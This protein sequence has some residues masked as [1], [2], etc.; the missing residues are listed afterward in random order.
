MTLS[1][2]QALRRRRAIAVRNTTIAGE[3]WR[4]IPG[5]EDRYQVSDHGRVRSLYRQNKLADYRTQRLSQRVL[6]P[7]PSS[8]GRLRV[9]IAAGVG[10]GVQ[11][12]YV[13]H[14]V[15][16]AFVGPRPVGGVGSHRDGDYSNNRPD[17]LLWRTGGVC[18]RGHRRQ[19][20]NLT[21]HGAC[22]ACAGGHAAA[23]LARNRDLLQALGKEAVVQR[24][25][26]LIYAKLTSS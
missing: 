19:P 26:D 20:P 17:N 15:L 21:A 7:V 8:D 4:P 25:A 12:R 9:T 5:L 18:S 16:E 1:N 11:T 24:E 14:L 3:Q 2:S 22:V 6:I 13:H 10:G 23:R